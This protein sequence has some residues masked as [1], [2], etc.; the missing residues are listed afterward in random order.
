LL[1]QPVLSSKTA[2]A[3]SSNLVLPKSAEPLLT[4]AQVLVVPQGTP[5]VNSGMTLAEAS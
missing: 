2:A 4:Q 3:T 5:L 1:E